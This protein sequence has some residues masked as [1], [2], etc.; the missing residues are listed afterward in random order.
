MITVR[1]TSD[2]QIS[3]RIKL[4]FNLSNRQPLLCKLNYSEKE[5]K[6]EL[7]DIIIK[8]LTEEQ[9]F[10]SEKYGYGEVIVNPVTSDIDEDIKPENIKVGVNILGVEGGYEGMDTSDATAEPEDILIGETAYANGKKIE[11][12]MQIY[13]GDYSGDVSTGFQITDASYL[14]YNKSRINVLNELINLCGKVTDTQYMFYN[15]GN[16]VVDENIKALASLD[17]SETINMRLMFY[18]CYSLKNLILT[19]FNTS[20]V[21]NMSNMFTSCSALEKLD[22]SSFD[23]SN[24]T[25]MYQMFNYCS[26][27][28][29]LDLSSFNMQ[30]VK[31]VSNIL[32]S[33]TQLINLKSF[34][35][36][37]K[38]YTQKTNS[39][40][41]YSLLLVYCNNLTYESLIDVITNGL[42]DLNLTYDVANGGT[43]YTQN[44]QLGPT[45]LAKLTPEEIRNSN[46]QR[47]GGFLERR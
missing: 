28:T 38:G 26:K 44:L 21:I 20:K 37:G 36:L 9:K 32:T 43:L 15:C 41:D 3:E 47:M 22:V 46:S 34:K 16:T 39:Y 8:P 6:P 40:S 42:Y 18:S 19:N 33:C 10:K 35:N 27:L 23:T 13:D 30:K 7:E 1:N 25:D 11:G 12:S 5:T 14:F 45:N 24:V 29:N 2:G 31:N 17:T 4:T